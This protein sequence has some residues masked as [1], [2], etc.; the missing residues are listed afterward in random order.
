MRCLL[1]SAL[2]MI[3]ALCL[4]VVSSITAPAGQAQP[5]N[6][7]NDLYD[8]V[9]V[10]LDTSDSMTESDSSGTQRIVGARSAVLGLVDALPPSSPFAL[11]AYP[12]N[13]GRVVDGCSEGKVEIALGPLDQVTTSA[14]VRRLRPDGDTPTAPALRHAAR[15]IQNGPTQQGTIVLVSDGESNCGS[16]DV[17]EVARQLAADGVEVRVNT[18]GFQ[19]SEEGAEELTCI[20][21]ATGGSYANADDEEQLRKTLQDFS[22]ARL[23]LTAAVPDPLAVVSGTGDQG[24]NAVL[25]VTNSGRKPAQ[26]VRL[27]LDFRDRDNKPGAVLIPRPIRFLGN[28]APGASHTVTIAIRP[29]ASRI[30]TFEWTASA[31]AKNAVP[32]R[33]T[34]Q[35]STAEGKLTGLLAGVD[36]LAVVGDS[37]SSGLGAGAYAAGTTGEGDGSECAQSENAYGK[38]LLADATLIACAGAVTSDFYNQQQSGSRKIEPQLKRLRRVA[39]SDDSPDAVLLSI[40]GNDIDFVGIVTAC[41]AAAPG[42]TCTWDGPVEEAFLRDSTAKRIAGISNS[43]RRVYRDVNRAVNDS[44]ARAKRDGAHAP[45]IVVPYPRIVPSAQAGAQ[46][47]GGCQANINA[48]EIAFFN[49]VI[50]MLNLEIFA[51]VGSLRSQKLPIYVASDVVSAFQPNHTI[52]DGSNSYAVFSADLLTVIAGPR[53]ELLHPNKAGHE[54]MARTISVWA[55]GQTMN[56][57]PAEVSWAST[58]VKKLD[59]LTNAVAS[60]TLGA[61]DLYL[62]GGKAHIDAQGFAPSSTVVFRLDSTPRIVGSATA[63]AAGN[64]SSNVDL[65][66][67]IRPGSHTLL[68]MGFADDG[69]PHEVAQAI[70]LLAPHTLGAL[71]CVLAGIVALGAGLIGMRRKSRQAPDQSA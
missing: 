20:S 11:I 35:S 43:I 27:S 57:N 32:Q 37:Y 40:G 70:K 65:P 16:T 69:K 63:D 13:G 21:D 46:A 49:D 23:T 39:I 50:D 53:S 9:V 34:G 45:I 10:V 44:Q 38:V 41:T 4:P 17:C 25:T 28:L 36:H 66:P 62:V 54:A 60:V 7:P 18:V 22:G 58:E 12:G 5:Q 6:A 19:I 59:P 15:L 52:C 42:Q 31:T 30:E 14:A 29:D 55:A 26:D 1:R 51:A 2:A 33:Q 3:L 48:D 56:P 67:D 47:A 64:V 8:P 71:V 24:P 68:A 61:A